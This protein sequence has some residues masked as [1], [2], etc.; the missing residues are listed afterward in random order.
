MVGGLNGSAVASAE[1]YD[2]ATGLWTL[3]ASLITAR[4]QHTATLLPSG[5]VL[6]VGGLASSAIGDAA[7]FDPAGNAGAGSW[8]GVGGGVAPRY[9]HTATLLLNG[10]VFIAGGYGPVVVGGSS[11]SLDS[12]ELYDPASIGTPLSATGPL[13]ARYQHTATL[14]PTGRVFVAGGQNPSYSPLFERYDLRG[15]FDVGNLK[16]SFYDPQVQASASWDNSGRLVLNGNRLRGISSGS[17]GNGAQDSA[18]NFPVVQL[19]RLDN[20]QSAFLPPD[21]AGY[22]SSSAFVSG[23]LPVFGAGHVMV[24]VFVNGIPTGAEIVA[25]LAPGII[26]EQPANS[27]IADGGSRSFSATTATPGVL[28]FTI[29][30]TG[31]VNLTGLSITKDG[32]NS[33]DFTVTVNP[34]P[35]VAPGS[36]TT[37][38]IQFAPTTTGAK[39]AAVHIANSVV[40][41][42]PYDITLTGQL[43][44][45]ATDTDGDGMNDAAEFDLAS[46]GF[47]WQT[48]QPALVTNYYANASGAGLY[49]QT[50]YDGYYDAGVS[51]GQN[52]VVTT[53]SNYNLYTSAEYVAN[54]TAGQADVINSPNGF[55]LFTLSQVKAL[56]VDV[57]LL[58][59]DPAT[60]K[61]KLTIGVKKSN[62]LATVPFSDFPMNGAGMTSVINAAGKVEFVFPVSDS[63]AFFR[64][65]SSVIG[66]GWSAQYYK[67]A[68]IGSHLAGS[69]LATRTDSTIN[70]N[71]A[72]GW[73]NTL[74]P[75][76]GTTSYSVRW[77]GQFLAPATATYTFYTTS[78]DGVRFSINGQTLIDNWT[79]HGPTTNSTTVTLT[80]GQSYPIVL[81]FYQNGAGAVISLEYAATAA[82]IARQIM[83]PDRVF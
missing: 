9:A 78:D 21:P 51:Y 19:R 74:I 27:A 82:G 15:G 66:T 32:P 69:P 49:N 63:T 31:S 75:G 62:S 29:K 41:K 57:P 23:V 25:S 34:T 50:Q 10:L 30:N 8:V 11:A 53:P 42:T 58:A 44:S 3:T 81:E 1:L 4:S 47:N 28:T 24:T 17:G 76:I 37:F 71:S 33:A 70:F 22:V 5:K 36:T 72:S 54:R 83:P 77:S 38:T 43:L 14:L 80:A 45:Y 16:A 2:P 73:P 40:G 61:F 18:T 12:A 26:V 56:N 67:D 60:G 79:D 13:K 65:E 59:K 46:Q 35:S 7:L 55:G 20:E 48:S 52:L 39:V 6:V 64:L 68:A